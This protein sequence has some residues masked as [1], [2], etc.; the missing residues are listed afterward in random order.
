[1]IPPK[2]SLLCRLR[3]KSAWASPYPHL[4]HTIPDFI[5]TGSLSAELSPNVWRPFL[6]LRLEYLQYRLFESIPPFLNHV[7]T[8]P[9]DSLIIVYVSGYCCYSYLTTLL[10]RVA[11]HY[12][13]CGIFFIIILLQ[14]YYCVLWWLS[15]R[16][17]D[18][19]LT[20]CDS[21][22]DWSAFT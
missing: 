12:R 11:T 8:L 3:P 7:D 10:N 13:G 2:L 1:M 18:L 14:I 15:G 16:A 22:P 20:G 4:A 21:I 19:W 6:P 9:C 5:H 17:L